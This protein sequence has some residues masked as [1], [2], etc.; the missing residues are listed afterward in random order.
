[1]SHGV[2][3]KGCVFDFNF[4]DAI[5]PLLHLIRVQNIFP[6]SS[7][8]ITSPRMKKR[9]TNFVVLMLYCPMLRFT[10]GEISF[11][12]GMHSIT[13]MKRRDPFPSVLKANAHQ[14]HLSFFPGIYS[15]PINIH[16]VHEKKKES[17]IT[18]PTTSSTSFY[19]FCYPYIAF[20]RAICR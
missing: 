12:I 5:L 11:S 8:R 13:P 17:F 16:P 7:S 2:W 15:R 6:S 1:M 18:I 19:H 10:P 14:S 4:Q 20:S 3:L 9:V